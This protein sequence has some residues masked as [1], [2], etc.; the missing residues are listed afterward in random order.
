MA[1]SGPKGAS[2]WEDVHRLSVGL[3]RHRMSYDQ[4]DA[5]CADTNLLKV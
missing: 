4:P 3:R 1:R 5:T 2:T